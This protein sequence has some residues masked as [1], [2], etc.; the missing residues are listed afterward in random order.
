MWGNVKI[1]ASALKYDN[2]EGL[3]IVGKINKYEIDDSLGKY[4]EFEKN[5]ETIKYSIGI[6]P[7]FYN[8]WLIDPNRNFGGWNC[9][10]TGS[11]SHTKFSIR[12]IVER[13]DKLCMEYKILY[14]PEIAKLP[15]GLQWAAI[16]LLRIFQ[17][18]TNHNY[19]FKKHTATDLVVYPLRGH[20]AKYTSG[21]ANRNPE[22]HFK[23]LDVD[24]DVFGYYIRIENLRS[25]QQLDRTPIRIS[26][27][28]E[29]LNVGVYKF[30]ISIK[31]TSNIWFPYIV[32]D[33]ESTLEDKRN[34]MYDN[35]YLAARNTPFL[36]QMISS[37]K[38][39]CQDLNAIWEVSKSNTEDCL[40][41][42]LINDAGI[43]IG[44]Q[45]V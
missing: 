14:N 12:S 42:D 25:I 15:N 3:M 8:H 9:V 41:S 4:L 45:R 38:T 31:I 40:Y 19:T 28:K 24:E 35:R 44:V 26:L 37:L 21:I 6:R 34:K 29:N 39:H 7:T 23:N 18:F 36:N 20:I 17:S 2:N 27:L 13:F 32:L 43:D 22:I 10:I 1:W 33:P 5:I 16:R 11:N 30:T